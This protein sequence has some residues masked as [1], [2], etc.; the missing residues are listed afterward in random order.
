V[1]RSPSASGSFTQIGTT[2]AVTYDDLALAP[3]TYYYKVQATKTGVSGTSPDSNVASAVVGREICVV[4]QATSSVVLHSST[5]DGDV[6]PARTLVGGNTLLSSPSG[7]AADLANNE[8]YVANS[9]VMRVS[10]YNR[11][12]ADDT[13][14]KRSLTGLNSP[15]AVAVDPVNN[16][17]YVVSLND[18]S[19]TVYDRSA[20]W[21]SPAPKRKVG[22][23]SAVNTTL[24]SPV[25]IAYDSVNSEFVVV[26]AQY[27]YRVAT[28]SSAADGDVAPLR[29]ITGNMTQLNQPRAVAVDASNNELV[30]ANYGGSY[31]ISVYDRTLNGNVTTKRTPISGALTTLNKPAGLIIDGTAGTY[32][33]ANFNNGAGGSVTTF[34]RTDVGN[35]MPQRTLAGGKTGLSGP[36]GI[37]FCK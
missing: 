9:S 29:S 35:L 12:D 21:P 25:G 22:S 5:I 15:Q 31:S 18:A 1:L 8:I 10:V 3:G 2:A 11:T 23:A 13:G 7:I 33:V 14:P 32:L 17:L 16:E 28:W 36:W 30:V 27:P 24:V 20:S 19:I 26:D 37:S 6:F 4:A 34:L